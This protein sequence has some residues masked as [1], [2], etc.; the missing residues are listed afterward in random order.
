M[1]KEKQYFLYI[2]LTLDKRIPFYV[3]KGGKGRIK[4][5]SRGEPQNGNEHS[6]H[7][8]IMN[9]HGVIRMII[10]CENN[11]DAIEKEIFMIEQL[12]TYS[13]REDLTEKEKYYACNFTI[14]GE[15]ISGLKFSNESRQKMLGRIPWNKGKKDIYSEDTRHEIGN[16]RRGKPPWSKNKSCP[17]LASWFDIKQIDIKTGKIIETYNSVSDISMATTLFMKKYIRSCLLKKTKSALG[18][19]W[20]GTKK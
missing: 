1:K 14:G 6:K 11:I 8:N 20:E 2:D 19:Y 12:R 3:G 10:R 16:G 18:F 9:K 5:L 7:D 13:Y 17:Q 4:K 15:G